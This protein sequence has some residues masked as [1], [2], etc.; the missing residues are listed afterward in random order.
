MSEGDIEKVIEELAYFRDE[1]LRLYQE[2]E[3]SDDE[4]IDLKGFVNTIITNRRIIWV[5]NQSLRKSP[6]FEIVYPL[7]ISL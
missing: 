6:L 3:L 5:R 7:K 1:M 2:G 4:L